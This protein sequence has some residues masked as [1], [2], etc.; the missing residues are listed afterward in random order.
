M[1]KNEEETEPPNSYRFLFLLPSS[2]LLSISLSFILF[3]L[4]FSCADLFFFLQL[5]FM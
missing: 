3:L 4:P 5:E 1:L 2:S